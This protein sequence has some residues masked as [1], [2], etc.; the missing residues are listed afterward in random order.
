MKK[1][2]E[3]DKIEKLVNALEQVGDALTKMYE[4]LADEF[5]KIGDRIAAVLGGE[6]EDSE[7]EDAALAQPTTRSG[8]D[9]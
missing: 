2:V 4:S 1:D 8:S 7:D 9:A 5:I 6:D 3:L